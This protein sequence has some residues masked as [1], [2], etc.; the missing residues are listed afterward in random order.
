MEPGRAQRGAPERHRLDQVSACMEAL[1]RLLPGPQPVAI[2]YGITA[3]MVM[4]TFA[5]RVGIEERSGT[6][7]PLPVR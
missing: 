2:R 3:G 4:L 7:E 6:Y 1:I 5:V